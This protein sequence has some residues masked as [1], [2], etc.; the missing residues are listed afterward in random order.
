MSSILDF[1]QAKA[2]HLLF[3]S[4]LRTI[5]YDEG[6]P[7][8]PQ[9]LSQYACA[10]GKWLYGHALIQ[11]ETI[12]EVFT[13]EE[14]H[15]QLHRIARDLVSRYQQGQVWEARQGLLQLEQVADQLVD[16]LQR[17]ETKVNAS[18]PPIASS[19]HAS[20]S[21]DHGRA[22]QALL[23]QNELL[24][25]KIK[26]L[27][28]QE[29][30]PVNQLA[31]TQQ[32]LYPFLWQA[33][34]A[35]CILRGPEHTFELANPGYQQL[36]GGRNP[37]GQPVRRALPELAGQGFF[38]LLD[39][40]YTTQQPFT[41][42]NVPVTLLDPSGQ[43]RTAYIDFSYQP[44]LDQQGQTVGIL[45]FAYEVTAQVL[46]SQQFKESEHRFRSL[47]EE[48]PVATCLFVG[49]EQRIDM[50]NQPMISIWGKGHDVIGKPLE[51]ALPELKGQPFLSILD[52]VFTSGEAYQ[53][54]GME[55][56]LVVNGVAGTYYFD[57]TYKPLRNESGEVYGI[58][59]MAVDV[60]AQVLARQELE[61]SEKRFRQ[62]VEQA[63]VAIVILK[64]DSLI[65]ETANPAMLD[66][67][68]RGAD[69]LGQPLEVVM[70]EL[71]GQALLALSQRVYETGEP[72][73]GW[74]QPA[75]INRNGQI[76]TGYFNVSYTPFYE[77]EHITGVLQI[78]SEVTDQV[79][80]HQALVQSE[81]RYRHLAGALEQQV[82][83]RTE[84]LVASNGELAAINE[85]LASTNE[86]Y[87]ASNKELTET[88]HLLSRSNENLQQF[89]YVASH[90]LQ[91]PLRKIQQFGD[92]L[93]EQY[94][95]QLGTG[96]DYLNR[97]QSAASRMSTLIRDLLTYSRIA[98]Q[99]ETGELVALNEVVQAVLSDLEVMI[100]ETG[101][102]VQVK[103]LPTVRGDKLQLGQLFQNLLTNALKFRQPG[104]AP[105]VQ[106]ESH[107]V[108]LEELPATAKPLRG[109]QAYHRIEIADNGIG[110]DEKYL[111]RM[112][113]VFQRLHGGR[114][115]AGTGIGLA[116]CE[117]VVT[118]HGG[119]ITAHSQLGKGA[120]FIVYL[121]A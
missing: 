97:M 8:D 100:E 109:V 18:N 24:D 23:A 27:A 1:Q 43:S 26:Q 74:S 62:A 3:K 33:P 77:G 46:V 54:K 113:Q 35:F 119:F 86:Q 75:Q 21:I 85:E 51:E 101:A 104:V 82:Q 14:V 13:L 57:F 116:I 93:K 89:A 95:D 98:S 5:L 45:V 88:T 30:L 110:F 106:I 102:H 103:N 76:E 99:Q 69:S 50:A 118:N 66:L 47:I 41:G 68:G 73:F 70:P 107:E 92:L 28:G 17:V 121:P 79:L 32:S 115:Y 81:T 58:I 44:I 31:D 72:Y 60:T 29:M 83:Q 114:T 48:A 55:C 10:I 20:E 16:L 120:T 36:I 12:P 38:E 11:Y 4:R 6:D 53:A 39:N 90:D 78:V 22:L 108:G 80:A 15:S 91:E 94:G 52:H 71:D 61:V 56:E 9:V 59:D 40:V 42:K 96:T 105:V 7:A 34:A 65:I 49:R 37:I 2:N 87:A 25:S 84:E 117:K 19:S 67:M 111:D 64:G 112:F 63:P